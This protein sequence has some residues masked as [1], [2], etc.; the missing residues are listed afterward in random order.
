MAASKTHP[1]PK[2]D[3]RMRTAILLELNGHDK[4]ERGRRIRNDRLVAKALIRKGKEGDIPAI[5]E[6]NDR[7][8]GKIINLAGMDDGGLSLED[9]IHMSYQ[10]GKQ[11]AKRELPPPI[12]DITPKRED[13]VG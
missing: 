9:L 8:D 11:K 10:V 4:D 6:I 12:I 2:S 13:D 1:G 7:V 5:K 3:K